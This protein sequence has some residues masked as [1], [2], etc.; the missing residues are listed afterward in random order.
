MSEDVWPVPLTCPACGVPATTRLCRLHHSAS[1]DD[2]ECAICGLRVWEGQ[3]LARGRD[4]GEDE[5]DAEVARR[6]GLA[7]PLDPSLQAVPPEQRSVGLAVATD[8]GR[9]RPA[10]RLPS[11]ITVRWRA[12]RPPEAGR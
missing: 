5:V 7:L 6:L 10:P 1:G 3:L 9:P 11:S 4:L 2:I 12:D 8:P